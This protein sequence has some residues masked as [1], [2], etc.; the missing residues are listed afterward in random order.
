[1]SAVYYA[2]VVVTAEVQAPDGTILVEAGSRRFVR[3]GEWGL[4]TELV[5]KD[6]DASPEIVTFTS[7]EAA[8]DYIQRTPPKMEWYIVPAHWEVVAVRPMRRAISGYSPE[9]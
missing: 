2:P 7:R 8:E 1:M 5:R 3:H 4:T 9:P 6:V